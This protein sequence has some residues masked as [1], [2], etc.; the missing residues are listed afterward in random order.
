MPAL[1]GAQGARVVTLS[2]H[3]HRGPGLDLTDLNFENRRYSPLR[4]Y[5][6]SKLANLLFAFELHRRLGDSGV[7]S[8]AAHPG[9]TGSDLVAN[10]AQSFV[11][12]RRAGKAVATVA[13]YGYKLFSQSTA[14]GAL[15]QLYAATAAEARGGEYYGPRG[16]AE[17][18]GAPVLVKARALARD[19]AAAA[20]LWQRSAEMTGVTPDP[21]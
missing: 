19:D 4:G 10:S 5:S 11:G 1:R 6:Q 2:S 14:R 18:W 13:N 20:E 16:P 12:S 8:V 21:R 15:P 9:S 3:A 7:T 17:L